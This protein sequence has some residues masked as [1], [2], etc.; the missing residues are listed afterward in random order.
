ML[1]KLWGD[2]SLHEALSGQV[3]GG[4]WN[5]KSNGE[6]S[7]AASKRIKQMVWKNRAAAIMGRRQYPHSTLPRQSTPPQRSYCVACLQISILNLEHLNSCPLGSRLVRLSLVEPSAL[8]PTTSVLSLQIMGVARTAAV[9]RS[10][11]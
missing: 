8:P 9:H 7:W 10:G 4:R 6:K 11:V 5:Q 3:D 2:I 1:Q